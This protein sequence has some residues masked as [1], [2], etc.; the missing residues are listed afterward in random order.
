MINSLLPGAAPT[1]NGG[2]V[3]SAPA[4]S[5]LGPEQGAALAENPEQNSVADSVAVK[6]ILS[7][8]PPALWASTETPNEGALFIADNI[9]Q[10][11]QLGL[12]L[13]RGNDKIVLF[14]PQVLPA[15]KVKT[16]D[17]TGELEKMAAP[18]DQFLAPP[19][20]APAPGATAP[21]TGVGAAP[22]GAAAPPVPPPSVGGIPTSPPSTQTMRLQELQPQTPSQRPLPGQGVVINGL[23]RR[24]V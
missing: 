13:Y 22:A 3:L 1:Q 16:L 10:L 21:E 9:P 15:E 20:A 6:A 24:A 12:G 23:L 8:Q 5:D 17:K 19:E 18:F 7:G 4:T 14:N 11:G 2:A